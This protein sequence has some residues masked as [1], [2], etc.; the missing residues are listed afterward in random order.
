MADG[1]NPPSEALLPT[2]QE[3]RQGSIR[4]AMSAGS[5]LEHPHPLEEGKAKGRSVAAPASY[6]RPSSLR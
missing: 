1:T 4:K 5:G 6:V 3:A 2:E